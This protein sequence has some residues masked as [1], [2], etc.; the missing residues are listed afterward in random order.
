MRVGPLV[1]IQHV[2]NG[3]PALFVDDTP[4]CTEVV[5]S[6]QEG[7]HLGDQVRELQSYDTAGK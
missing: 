4:R 3:S 7:T 2:H 5:R 1:P 6:A